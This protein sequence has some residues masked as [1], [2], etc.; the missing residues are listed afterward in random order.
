MEPSAH[1][2]ALFLIQTGISEVLDVVVGV[3]STMIMKEE[4][5]TVDLEVP[6]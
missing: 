6:Y 4:V 3:F 2:P 5:F 1:H